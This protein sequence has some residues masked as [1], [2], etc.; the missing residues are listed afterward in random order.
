MKTRKLAI[1]VL[2]LSGGELAFAQLACGPGAV[3]ELACQD[4]D[5]RAL[6]QK[7][8]DEAARLQ[9]QP[10]A[11]H[12][13]VSVKLG[14]LR[15]QGACIRSASV[16]SCVVGSLESEIAY[17]RAM[18]GCELAANPVKFD[19]TEPSYIVAHIDVF[20]GSQVAVMGW[21]TL[22]SCDAGSTSFTGEV[23]ELNN[24]SVAIEIRFRSLP[25]VQRD[26]VCEKHPFS[27]WSAKVME[28]DSGA[29]YLY[30][31]D[32]LGVQLP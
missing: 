19:T 7:V 26:F 22:A 32:L 30:A 14:W 18:S 21:L 29:P 11:R 10:A 2:A 1:G 23:H 4:Q 24:E 20:K 31:T 12:E 25:D 5:V 6:V 9:C 15:R 3:Q 17:F 8:E 16:R 28:T 27:A 13:L